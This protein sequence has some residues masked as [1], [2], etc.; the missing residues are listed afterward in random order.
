MPTIKQLVVGVTIAVAIAIVGVGAF[1]SA[2]E[3]K[4]TQAPV[5]RYES[6]SKTD[7]R[8]S[9]HQQLRRMFLGR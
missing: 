5:N 8:L 9:D 1:G 3:H 6:S 2:V 7:F 4:T